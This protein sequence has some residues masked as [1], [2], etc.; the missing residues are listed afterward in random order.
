LPQQLAPVGAHVPSPQHCGAVVPQHPPELHATDP[1]E[2]DAG[3]FTQLVVLAAQLPPSQQTVA[4]E[5]QVEPFGQHVAPGD[6][7]APLQQLS[8]EEQAIPPQQTVPVATHAVPQQKAPG[9][10]H[11]DPHASSPESQVGSVGGDWFGCEAQ[12]GA[13]V[14]EQVPSEQ[15]SGAAVG[16]QRPFSHEKG[17]APSHPQALAEPQQTPPESTGVSSGQHMLDE[18]TCPER[19]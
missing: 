9:M 17:V 2:Q 11:F 10:Q 14:L 1:E 12:Y 3:P 8:P 16:Q 6:R 5:G 19:Q 4:G 7:Q 18:Q 15:Q 13:G